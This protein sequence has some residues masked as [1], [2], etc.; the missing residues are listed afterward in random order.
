MIPT[1]N[2]MLYYTCDCR[3]C[4][5]VG[6]TYMDAMELDE[7]EGYFGQEQVPLTDEIREILEDYS[8]GQIFKVGTLY[9]TVSSYRGIRTGEG[10]E[11][12]VSHTFCE[13]HLPCGQ[14]CN[15]RKT[16]LIFLWKMLV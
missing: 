5:I 11:G 15:P 9:F 13:V 8:D 10:V 2:F 12:H 3:M 4:I 7:G 6:S 14:V 16:S 1:V